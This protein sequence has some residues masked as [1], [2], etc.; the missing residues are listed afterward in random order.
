[1]V[2]TTFWF[3]IIFNK[4]KVLASCSFP[5]QISH[6]NWYPK[7]TKIHNNNKSMIFGNRVLVLEVSQKQF[8][9]FPCCMASIFLFDR[10]AAW[11]CDLWLLQHLPSENAIFFTFAARPQREARKS[12]KSHL[13][14]MLRTCRRE[15]CKKQIATKIDPSFGVYDQDALFDLCKNSMS[16]WRI[17]HIPQGIYIIS[18]L[19]L[20]CVRIR[21][22]RKPHN[23]SI[24]IN[25]YNGFWIFMFLPNHLPKS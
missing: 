2:L 4:S 7:S 21:N 12:W 10:H 8:F 9:A 15:R 3:F 5:P 1:M 19:A 20:A 24:I 22:T 25:N 6:Q 17:V 13:G 14:V 23:M 18:P 16:L 11:E